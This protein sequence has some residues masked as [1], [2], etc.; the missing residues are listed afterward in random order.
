L[1]NVRTRRA[2][3]QRLARLDAAVISLIVVGLFA[4]RGF[5]GLPGLARL[6]A[7]NAPVLFGFLLAV[8]AADQLPRVVVP[9]LWAGSFCVSFILVVLLR[10]LERGTAK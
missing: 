2:R 6:A 8:P 10:V 5:L 3:L 1:L 7:L 9:I 4:L